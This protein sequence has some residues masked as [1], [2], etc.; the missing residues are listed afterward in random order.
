MSKLNSAE[1]GILKEVSRW[2]ST[3]PG[4][5]SKATHLISKPLVWAADALIPDSAKDGIGNVTNGVI[6]RLQ[7]LSK[8]TV[9]EDEVLK[10]TKEFEIDSQT[11]LELRKAS[12]F[13]LDTVAE[14]F[15]K[16]NAQI[17]AAEGFGTGL[18]GWAGLIA[19]MPALFTLSFR[20]IYQTSLTYGYPLT[21]ETVGDSEENY[22]VGFMLRIFRIATAA[23]REAKMKGLLDLKDYEADHRGDETSKL[24][25]DYTTQQLSKTAIIGFS[26]MIVNE[27]VRQTFARKA[28]TS[29]PGIGAVLT[30]GFNYAYVQDVGEAAAML[31]R[32]RFLLDKKGRKRIIN[33][34]IE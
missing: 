21:D 17:A 29:I 2:K 24:G 22:E 8:W 4:F 1:E 9:N 19:D 5:L 26:R 30:A 14:S 16:T 31:Y 3:G 27:I 18:I 33:I 11:I 12:I 32:E 13:D 34:N 28:I 7:D 10:A 20:L 23:D 6:D 15:K 25:T